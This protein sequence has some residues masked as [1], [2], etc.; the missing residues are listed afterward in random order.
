MTTLCGKPS[1]SRWQASADLPLDRY[2]AAILR[3]SGPTHVQ[4]ATPRFEDLHHHFTRAVSLPLRS[5]DQGD[6]DVSRLSWPGYNEWFAAYLDYQYWLDSGKV[7]A[8]AGVHVQ[9]ADVQSMA[10]VWRWWMGEQQRMNGS[11]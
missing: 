7:D 3:G 11:G 1:P 2:D 5:V 8:G 10:W 4:R 6:L 9:R